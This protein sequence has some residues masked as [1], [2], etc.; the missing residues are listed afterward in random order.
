MTYHSRHIIYLFSFVLLLLVSCKPGVPSEIIQ[1]SEMEELLYDYALADGMA[2]LQPGNASE[3]DITLRQSVLQKY[4][5]SQADFDS[6][7][8][9][10]TRHSDQLRDIYQHVCDRLQKDAQAQGASVNETMAGVMAVDSIDIWRGERSMVLIPQAPYNCYS[11]NLKPDKKIRRG[12]GVTLQFYANFIYQ[13]GMRDGVAMLAVTYNNDSTVTRTTHI[14][15]T[16]SY[17][18]TIDDRDSL[19]IKS[20]RGFFIL[21]KNTQDQSATTLRL[22]SLSQIRMLRHSPQMQPTQSAGGAVQPAVR[23]NVDSIRRMEQQSR[24]GQPSS[25]EPSSPSSSPT[26]APATRLSDGRPLPPPP[27]SEGK[28][29]LEM[30]KLPVR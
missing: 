1:P 5:V 7:M 29:K 12:D 22:M 23:P 15:S 2:S 28:R 9:Y 13:D 21:N 27:P 11:Y 16:M 30:K 8:V 24:Q 14:S 4:D 18:L 20:V 6:S 17:S 10:Y 19:G 26:L 3:N 25:L